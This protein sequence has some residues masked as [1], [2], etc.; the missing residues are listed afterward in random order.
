MVLF[1]SRVWKGESFLLLPALRKKWKPLLDFAAAAQRK[2]NIR[3]GVSYW[4]IR[5]LPNL[6]RENTDFWDSLS[7]IPQRV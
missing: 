6:Q 5:V 3:K 4:K 1:G 2:C 7:F